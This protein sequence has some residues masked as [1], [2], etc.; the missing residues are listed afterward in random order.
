MVRFVFILLL[1]AAAALVVALYFDRRGRQDE[2]LLRLRAAF[3]HGSPLGGFARQTGLQDVACGP[4]RMRLPQSFLP[5]PQSDGSLL[6][7]DGSTR[8][9]TLRLEVLALQCTAPA[10][11]ESLE[12]ELARRKPEKER[13]L[14]RLGD[15]V[16]LRFL[17]RQ[18][19]GAQ[20]LI[21]YCWQ[22]GLPLPPEQARLALLT[23][24]VPAARAGD[25]V[26]GADL[27]LLERE[28]RAATL[29]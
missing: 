1:V 7:R 9:N 10:S 8:V 23:F 14:E 13:S 2:G 18:R 15:R 17:E 21:A 29:G 16:L 28:I 3:L 20:D 11:A 19:E 27:A 24:K 4:L 26:V 12:Q 25:V 5:E 6:Y 22:L